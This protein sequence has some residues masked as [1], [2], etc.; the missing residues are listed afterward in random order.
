MIKRTLVDST[1][2]AVALSLFF[3]RFPIRGY[4]KLGVE[5]SQKKVCKISKNILTCEQKFDKMLTI[6]G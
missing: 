1:K 3:C 4:T 6:K 5:K 2:C